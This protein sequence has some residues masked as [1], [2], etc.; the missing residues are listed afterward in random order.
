MYSKLASAIYNDIVSGLSG[1]TTAPNLS[2]AQLEDDIVDERLKI[3][4]EYL[5]KG[6]LPK[7]QLTYTLYDLEISYEV[8]DNKVLGY[9]QVPQI[10]KGG[11]DYIGLNDKTTRFIVY[12]DLMELQYHKYRKRMRN[13]CNAWKPYVYIDFTPNCE[14]MNDVWIYNLPDDVTSITIVA[15]FKNLKQLNYNPESGIENET[16]I[17]NEIKRR[18]TEKKIRFYRQ[19]VV[20]N[21]INDQ[22]PK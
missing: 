15:V 2:L 4:Q 13:E 10:L 9:V 12:E 22:R 11:V 14:N 8:L 16:F 7:D 21:N 5:A 1:Y 17:N 18:L 19:G 20:I 6:L 3:I